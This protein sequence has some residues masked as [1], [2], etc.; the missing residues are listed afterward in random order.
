[1][2]KLADVIKYICTYYPYADELSKARLTKII[3]LADWEYAKKYGKQLSD[4]E[5]CFNHFGPYV[6]DVA[7][8]AR[9]DPDLEVKSELNYYNCRKE[10]IVLNR[11]IKA[12]KLTIEERHIIDAVMDKTHRMVWNDFIDHVYSTYPVKTQTRFS[13]LNLVELAKEEKRSRRKPM[14]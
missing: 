14:A 13:T 11:R 9:R 7:D 1:M 12:F 8:I 6:D 2:Q 5:W 4:I 10:R 3:Y